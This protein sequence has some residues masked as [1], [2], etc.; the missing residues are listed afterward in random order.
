MFRSDPKDGILSGSIDESSRAVC[1]A[2]CRKENGREN[3]HLLLLLNLGGAL[4]AGLLLRLA[5]LEKRLGDEN[6]VLGS[7]PT[8]SD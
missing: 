7:N 5:L 3:A 8:S 4:G 1:C 2:S 6:V